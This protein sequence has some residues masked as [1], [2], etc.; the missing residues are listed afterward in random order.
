MVC[1]REGGKRGARRAE[2]VD[3]GACACVVGMVGDESRLRLGWRLNG[4]ARKRGARPPNGDG[5]GEVTDSRQT[6]H[7]LAV[8]SHCY[9]NRH[10]QMRLRPRGKVDHLRRGILRA[11]SANS[12]S[13]FEQGQLVHT[14]HN[15]I[16]K[17]FFKQNDLSYIVQTNRTPCVS[18]FSCEIAIDS[19]LHF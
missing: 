3:V 14:V 17:R 8:C 19:F 1:R 11:A 18:A 5:L 16:S 12:C 2:A 4:I 9:E 6:G 7:V 10:G 15:N 13:F